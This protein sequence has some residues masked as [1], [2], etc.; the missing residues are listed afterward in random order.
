MRARTPLRQ[1]ALIIILY[2]YIYIVCI[3][4]YIQYIYTHMYIY[5]YIYSTSAAATRL[6]AEHRR[7][8]RFTIQVLFL[9]CNTHTHTR[10][11]IQSSNPSS[12]W[13]QVEEL[14]GKKGYFVIYLRTGIVL[15]KVPY[16]SCGAYIHV[17]VYITVPVGDWIALINKISTLS[18]A[19]LDVFDRWSF[20][21]PRSRYKRHDLCNIV[22]H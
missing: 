19:A 4:T 5:I 2:I 10:T 12:A 6:R 9:A 13:R 3:R 1:T 11:R 21:Y 7:R 22:I 14:E 16:I 15:G 18:C 8:T 17:C 20:S